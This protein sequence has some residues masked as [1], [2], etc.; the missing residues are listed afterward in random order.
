MC[1]V[2]CVCVLGVGHGA[3]EP[4]QQ[5]VDGLS[6]QR[7]ASL[8]HQLP[9]G[10]GGDRSF[11]LRTC[12]RFIRLISRVRVANKVCLS[13]SLRPDQEKA[14]GEPKVKKGKTLLDDDEDNEEE[15]DES[16][17]EVRRGQIIQTEH[18]LTRV[19]RADSVPT[20]GLRSVSPLQLAVKLYP[21]LLLPLSA[22]LDL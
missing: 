14:E 5:A 22:D 1:I 13:D 4:G 18:A 2:L 6:R 15:V 7:T 9:A 12:T 17:E 11:V 20:T 16:P 8:G 3:A 10:G 19:P 21:H